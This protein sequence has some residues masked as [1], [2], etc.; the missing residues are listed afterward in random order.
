MIFLAVLSELTDTHPVGQ[1]KE[2][3]DKLYESQKEDIEAK[4]RE[5]LEKYATDEHLKNGVAVVSI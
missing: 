3:M 2:M 1:V 4:K 5:L